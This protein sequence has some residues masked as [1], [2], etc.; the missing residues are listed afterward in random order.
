MIILKGERQSGKTTTLISKS[1]RYGVPIMC[2]SQERAMYLQKMAREQG[3]AIPVPMYPRSMP[4]ITVAKTTKNFGV[5]D[6]LVDDVEDVLSALIGC[7]VAYASTS[8]TIED[9]PREYRSIDNP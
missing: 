2:A 1:S 4:G 9:V 3:M 6:V 5:T 7:R 8:C